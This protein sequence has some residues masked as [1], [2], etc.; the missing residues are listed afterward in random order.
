MRLLA[1]TVTVRDDIWNVVAIASTLVVVFSHISR[2][3]ELVM[4]VLASE[5]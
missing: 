5:L 1:C 2:P 3:L 4:V